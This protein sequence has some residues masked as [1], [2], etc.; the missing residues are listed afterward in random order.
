MARTAPSMEQPAPPEQNA[1]PPKARATAWRCLGALFLIEASGFVVNANV[2]SHLALFFGI[3]RELATIASALLFL[4]LALVALRRPSFLDARRLTGATAVIAVL[5]GVVLAA[6]LAGESP[7]LVLAGL[8]CRAIGS[9]WVIALFS[10]ALSTLP[11][12]RS[13]LVV[14]GAGI[15]LSSIACAFIPADMGAPATCVALVIC[16]LVPMALV[17]NDAAPSFANIQQGAAA[18][19]L[20]LGGFKGFA[21][22]G[23][24]LLCVLLVGVASGYALAFNERDNAPLV[25]FAENVIVALALAVVLADKSHES[26]DR[27]FS[28]VILLLVA[29]F[30]VVP[31]ELSA[32]TGVA[33]VFLRA[34][35]DC[36]NLLL[37]ILLAFIGHRNVFVLLPMVGCVRAASSLG[38][39]LGAVSGHA[40]NYFAGSNPHLAGMLA[41][42]MVFCLVA[43]LWLG[44]R[45]FSFTAA[46]KEVKEVSE[47]EIRRLDN[48][49]DD[50]CL[51]LGARCG[52]TKRETEILVLLAKGR[53]GKFIAEKYVL[54]YQTVKTHIKHLYAKLGVHSRQEL[55]D[56]T[57]RAQLA[58][59]AG[60]SEPPR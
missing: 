51:A 32:D 11:T 59:G 37:W 14:T 44:F 27:L 60:H 28:L 55:I 10:V 34:G 2:Y 45:R 49:I 13:V 18:D 30:L 1:A 7:A 33:N 9:A 48:R 53:D 43:F 38:T 25:P 35:R 24:L 57:D 31:Y 3:G 23:A 41:S 8:L 40:T 39:T 21:P 56:L 6:G 17:W 52:L 42:A 5:A 54:S 12:G 26:E 46:V 50:A 15:L 16:M 19:G 58:E 20:G 47:P 4:A 22:L 36:F 29:G